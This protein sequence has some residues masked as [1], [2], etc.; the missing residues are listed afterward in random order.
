[1]R[2]PDGV[3]STLL[4]IVGLDTAGVRFA[5]RRRRGEALAPMFSHGGGIQAEATGEGL[6]TASPSQGR[7][8]VGRVGA[9]ADRAAHAM[10]PTPV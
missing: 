9:L 6:V 10:D 5:E 2:V 1:M 4:E 3:L 7:V 8:D